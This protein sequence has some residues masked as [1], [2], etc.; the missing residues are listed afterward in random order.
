MSFGV[1]Q[2]AISVIKSNRILIKKHRRH[3]KTLL[4]H[5]Y[6]GDAEYE[7]PTT[8]KTEL[9]QL[10]N[11]LQSEQKRRRIKILIFVSVCLVVMSSVFFYYY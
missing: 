1:V 8:T 9:N 6:K 4:G 2:H 5:D 7:F 10:K 11:R 3:S